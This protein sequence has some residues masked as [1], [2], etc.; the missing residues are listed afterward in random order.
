MLIRPK[1]K[2]FE[3]CLVKNKNLGING[4]KRKGFG[5][6]IQKGHGPIEGGGVIDL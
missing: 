5:W 4:L 6:F 1:N 2:H 3:I